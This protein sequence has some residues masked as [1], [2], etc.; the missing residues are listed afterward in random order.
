VGHE[1]NW[2]T[3]PSFTALAFETDWKTATFDEF[4]FSKPGV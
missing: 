1:L 2:R 4:Q 3:P